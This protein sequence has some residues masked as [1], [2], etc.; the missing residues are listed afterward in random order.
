MA[1]RAQVWCTL[2]RGNVYNLVLR[3]W[4][5]RAKIAN[6][7]CICLYCSDVQLVRSCEYY[8]MDPSVNSIAREI[9]FSSAC[10][11]AISILLSPPRPAALES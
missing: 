10:T 9:W 11:T 2:A 6:T 5:C 4:E 1:Y 7:Y 3:L 8:L